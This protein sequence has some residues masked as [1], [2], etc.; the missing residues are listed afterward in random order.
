MVQESFGLPGAAIP[1]CVANLTG[2]FGLAAPE[3]L[4]GMVRK[5][6]VSAAFGIES[7]IRCEPGS[8]FAITGLIG[9]IGARCNDGVDPFAGRILLM[10]EQA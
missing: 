5:E 2:V 1:P 3:M 6:N 8:F 10:E 9:G 7:Q 4:G